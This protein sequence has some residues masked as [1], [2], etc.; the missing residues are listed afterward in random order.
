M[1][2][3][4]HYRIDCNRKEEQLAFLQRQFPSEGDRWANA[5]MV[6]SVVGTAASIYNGSYEEERATYD[7][8]QQAVARYLIYQIRN[9]CRN[10]IQRP[11]GCVH[12]NEQLPGGSSQGA[13]CYQ[14]RQTTPVVK[15]WGVI[16]QQ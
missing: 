1:V 13:V 14:N 12:V 3:L 8:R 11:Q 15:R 4:N 7:R 5:F 9:N 6:T 10:D 2:D 16:D